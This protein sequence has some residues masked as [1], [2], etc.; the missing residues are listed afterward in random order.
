[1]TLTEI[2]LVKRDADG[3]IID[4]VYPKLPGNGKLDLVPRGD[5]VVRPGETLLLQID[6]DANKSIHIVGTGSGKY[7]FR[8]VVFVDVM[9]EALFGKLVRVHGVIEDIDG[10]DQEFKL[11]QTDIPVR[12]END[13]QDPQS[14][15]CIQVDVVNTSS[16]F[17]AEGRPTDFGAL[18]AGD[19]ATVY[20]NFRSDAGDDDDDRDDRQDD[21]YRRELD[22]LELVAVVVELGPEGTF[23]QLQGVAQSPVD[24]A[25]RF[26]LDTRSTVNE[27]L[28]PAPGTV[29]NFDTDAQDW[30]TTAQVTHNTVGTLTV[31]QHIENVEYYSPLLADLQAEFDGGLYRYVQVRLRKVAGTITNWEGFMY[32]STANHSWSDDY[33]NDITMPPGLEAGEWVTLTWDMHN[34][35]FGADDWKNNTIEHIRF[36]LSPDVGPV[37]EIDWVIIGRRASEVV[38]QLQQGTKII[39]RFGEPLSVGD[40]DVGVSLMADGVLD[41]NVD[42][43]VL[44]AALI[45]LDNDAAR[46]SKLSGT[47]G[48]IPDGSC[49]LS[50]VTDSGD[51]SVSYDSSTRAYLVSGG[52]SQQ[53]AVAAL[54]EGFLADVYGVEAIDG[55]FD[56]ETIIAFQ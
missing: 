9:S 20:G 41:M 5:F 45:V 18:V 37:F 27:V 39:N 7:Q 8:P 54:P 34:P 32:W 6:M 12:V 1:M 29:W 10:S 17:D 38:V 31:T 11:C 15:G 46:S 16:I 21:R 52:G 3:K 2:E 44:Y 48:T 33:R 14:P 22:D 36:D 40:I 24:A 4:T 56:A 47:L 43:D 13:Q 51:R 30:F 26:I 25:D 49:G 23:Q 55:C 50:L 28:E 53:L 42:P 35:T 19:E